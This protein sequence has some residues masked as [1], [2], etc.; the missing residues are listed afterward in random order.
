MKFGSQGGKSPYAA[1]DLWAQMLARARENEWST[2]EDPEHRVS[3]EEATQTRQAYLDAGWSEEELSFQEQATHERQLEAPVTSPGVPKFLEA[4]L[5][6]LSRAII[7][8]VARVDAF[9]EE[10]IHFAVEPRPGPFVSTINVVMTD[11]SIMTMGSF[12]TRYCGLVA[13]AY[14]RTTNLYPTGTGLDFDEKGL[15][16]QLRKNPDL[17]SYWWRIFVSFA[18]T[19]THALAPFKPCSRQE[20]LLMEQMAFAMEVFALAHE[21]AHHH[22]GHGRSFVS[23]AE[24]KQEEHEADL[25]AVKVCEAVEADE[26]YRW[27]RGAEL[28]NP[29]LSTGSGGVLLLGSLEIFRRVKSSV[30]ENKKYN[31]H[32]DFLDRCERIKMRSV[33]QPYKYHTALDF[34]GSAE[35]VLRCVQLELEPLMKA[36][37]FKTMARLLPGDWEVMAN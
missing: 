6:R 8:A 27:I 7:T 21:Y 36:Y 3:S 5:D 20:L 23:A 18:L 29:Y 15:R 24:A 31:T 12:F 1:V 26:R 9:D 22:H 25:Y 28:V 16:L 2:F 14:V 37:P 4:A 35:N 32:P 10:R 30:F 19:G 13:R 34:C 17:L 33:L 11:Q